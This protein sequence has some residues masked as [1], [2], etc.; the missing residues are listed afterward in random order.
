MLETMKIRIFGSR[1]N[2]LSYGF[3]SYELEVGTGLSIELPHFTPGVGGLPS[4]N[5]ID[6]ITIEPYISGDRRSGKDR[7]RL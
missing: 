6:T 2:G 4:G 3:G 7:R 1:E 5:I